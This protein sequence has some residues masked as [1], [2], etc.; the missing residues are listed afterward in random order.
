MTRINNGLWAG[1]MITEYCKDCIKFKICKTKIHNIIQ[2]DEY[3][4][5]PPH[6]RKRIINLLKKRG[7]N[8]VFLCKHK[9]LIRYILNR[10]NIWN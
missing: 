9:L 7:W 10:E 5:E 3:L 6:W 4:K 2:C 8:P 1:E